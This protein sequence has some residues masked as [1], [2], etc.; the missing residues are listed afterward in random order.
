MNL[1]LD[2]IVCL[3]ILFVVVGSRFDKWPAEQSRLFTGKPSD[4]IDSWR[5]LG[6]C[7]LYIL[8]FFVISAVLYSFP[9]FLRFLPGAEDEQLS[10]S[11]TLCALI[12]VSALAH[13]SISAY[14]EQWR[15]QLHEWARI[16]RYVE[17]VS[18]E[19]ILSDSFMPTDTYLA[20]LRKNLHREDG[21]M[22][23]WLDAI[24]QIEIEKVNH[25]I[26]W[27][28]LKCVSLMLII[29]DIRIGPSAYHLKE[30]ETRLEELARLIP[31]AEAG[32][33]EAIAYQKELESMSRYFIE[34]IC[35]YLIKKYPRADAQ[36]CAF[37][38]LGFKIRQHDTADVSIR[39]AIVWCT[40]GVVLVSVA[41]VTA[42]LF[43]LDDR[44]AVDFLTM[45]R[46][47]GWSLGNI[48]C[49]LIA[50][51]VG[52]LVKKMS[53][54]KARVS[55][56]GYVFAFF[57]STLASFMFFQ[58]AQD[59]NR[60][61]AHLPYA[62]FILAMSFSS[63]SVVV[64]RSMG[65]INLDHKDVIFSSLFQGVMLGLVMA[66]FQVLASIA[67]TWNQVSLPTSISGF[68]M[69]NNWKYPMLALVGF[70]KGLFVGTGISYFIQET[71]RKQLMQTSRQ[72]PRVE[73][74][75]F[76]KCNSEG[77]EF[78]ASTRDI[79]KSGFKLQTRKPLRYGDR[80]VMES[81]VFGR[82]EGVIKW[83]HKLFWG[84]RQ[85]GVQLTRTPLR[86]NTFLRDGYGEYY[87]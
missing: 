70:G 86:L 34:C 7:F 9:E 60:Q 56:N 36:F 32:D 13:Q 46:F 83:T 14:D 38:N 25:S 87:A 66:V 4:Y 8:T 65:N 48:E 82:V 28:F 15:Q 37:K 24:A 71:Q 85:V 31:S 73:R 53:A 3:L 79:S 11:Y 59:L 20:A 74:V 75:M 10:L 63:L 33:Q 35:K 67:F 27:Y 78:N 39:E 47:V 5:Y 30:K 26:D 80:L 19:I 62:R 6:F 40:L 42:L 52:L 21:S 43:I 68:L 57:L 72:N 51:L 76:L 54:G 29:Q 50:I 12:V 1:I 84:R 17:E 23:R 18:R 81:P 61:S 45:E 44:S 2:I 55:V 64:I 77:D 69:D 49:F 58:F 16:P 22:S 41:S